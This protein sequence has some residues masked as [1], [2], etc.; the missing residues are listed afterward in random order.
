MRGDTTEC[1]QTAQAGGA[2]LAFVVVN[3]LL[4]AATVAYGASVS[5][6]GKELAIAAPFAVVYT[7]AHVALGIVGAGMLLAGLTR[8]R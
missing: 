5:C 6:T 1:F 2:L 7:F 8:S 3:G 4:A